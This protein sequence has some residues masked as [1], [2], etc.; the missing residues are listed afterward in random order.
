MTELE[1]AIKSLGNRLE[2]LRENSKMSKLWYL[3]PVLLIF[4]Y[5]VWNNNSKDKSWSLSKNTDPRKITLISTSNTN[6]VIRTDKGEIKLLNPNTQ[7]VQDI[8]LGDTQASHAALSPD[9]QLVAYV[10]TNNEGSALNL[11]SQEGKVTPIFD[12]ETLNKA[13]K[14]VFGNDSKTKICEWNNNLYWFPDNPVNVQPNPSQLPS[15]TQP[16]SRSITTNTLKAGEKKLAFFTC[17]N[18]E[19]ILF[20]VTTTEDSSKI[21]PLW[22]T[23]ATSVEPRQA[24]LLSNGKII[25]T[26]G[27]LIGT[28]FLLE[29]NMDEEPIHLYG[30]LE[31][32]T[33]LSD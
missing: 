3:I 1:E 4:G 25:F 26:S 21:K 13:A 24:V 12:A 14:S 6:L 10:S 32:R 33:A 30:V 17:S 18:T 20:L 11:V 7:K 27:D 5:M 31:G 22:R 15:I 8:S 9:G 28:L 2:E 16:D 23:K 19:S 29:P